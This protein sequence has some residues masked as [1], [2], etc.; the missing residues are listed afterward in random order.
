MKLLVIAMLAV[1]LVGCASSA[2]KIPPAKKDLVV[3]DRKYDLT[4]LFSMRALKAN[5]YCKQ[6][7]SEINSLQKDSEFKLGSYDRFSLAEGIRFGMKMNYNLIP[8]QDHQD[9]R[10][11]EA[12]SKV[13]KLCK[14]NES[15][16]YLESLAIALRVISE[17]IN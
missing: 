17:P 5:I 3:D 4:V 8:S 10:Y 7:V 9:K 13:F 2:S 1:C 15:L 14:Q 16:T 6:L 12:Y 11:Q